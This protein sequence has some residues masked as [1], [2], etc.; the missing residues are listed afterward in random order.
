MADVSMDNLANLSPDLQ[1]AFKAAV[2][3]ERKPLKAIE[4][5]KALVEDR[6]RLLDDVIERVQ[7]VSEIMPNL[8]SPTAIRDFSVESQD[9]RV[10]VGTADKRL[11]Q[12]GKHIFEINS[13]AKPATAV[14]NRFADK[15]ETRVGSGYFRY[16]TKD[17]D[18][19]DIFIDNENATLEGL[20]GVINQ[21][22]LGLRASVVND[23]SDPD[24]P[25]RLLISHLEPGAKEDVEYPEFYFIDG[26]EDFYIEEEKSA[27]NAKIKYEGFDI[28][29]PTNEVKDLVRGIT[30]DL[31]GLTDMGKPVALTV[32]Q[33]IPKTT[34]KIK[35]MVEKVNR[36][37]SFIQEQ[38]TMD[39]NTDSSRTLGGDY[40]IRMTES[41]IREAL[42]E[43][44]VF[45][46]EENRPKTVQSLSDIGI[47]FT[48][49]GLLK[50]DEKK[51]EFALK[52]DFDEVTN[53]LAGDG[54]TYGV[55]TKLNNAIKTIA[56]GRDGLLSSQRLTY[57]NQ[58][59]GLNEDME[60]REKRAKDKIEHLKSRL[61]KAQAAMDMLQSQAQR[62]PAGNL[63]PGVE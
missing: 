46:D 10:L 2:E 22:G 12:P 50:F 27:T 55:M 43:N 37:F 14:S 18:T 9:E 33:D 7:G 3:V 34:L 11:A 60:T 47:E 54:R 58:I 29:S 17:G 40:S 35:E 42:R 19:K 59:K 30:V 39:E 16:T 28:E 41:R 36:V 63:M 31:R 24:L 49:Q 38:N 51:L 48:R 61:G 56:G 25:Y 13:L 21:S 4:D 62:L 26:Q 45:F 53:L 52:S 32:Q 6:V 15:D 44:F 20:A 5:R 57:K 23:E 1:R 8:N